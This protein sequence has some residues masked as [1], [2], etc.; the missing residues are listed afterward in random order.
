MRQL[1]GVAFAALLA[2]GCGGGGGP[3]IDSDVRSR[4]QSDKQGELDG[5]TCKSTCDG[6]QCGPDGCGGQCGQCEGKTEQ[7]SAEGLCEPFPCKS[8]K[9]CPGN[10]VCDETLERCVACLADEDCPQGLKCGADQACHEEHT[11][12]AD[13]ECKEFDLVCDKSSGKCVE[14]LKTEHCGEGEYCQEGFCIALI[15]EPAQAKCEG[16]Q[17]LVCTADGSGWALSQTCEEVQYC[18]D[19]KCVDLACKPSSRFCEGDLRKVCAEDGKSVV[20]QED[21]AA[22]NK[23]CFDGACIEGI[24]V[25]NEKFCV[26]GATAATCLADGTN[27][28]TLP[29]EGQQFCQDGACAAWVC[30]PGKAECAGAVARICNSLG[31]GYA[32]QMD[33]Q[34]QGKACIDGQCA[35]CEPQCQGKQCGEDGCGGNCGTCLPD[36]QC[37][38]GSCASTGLDCDLDGS[39]DSCPELTGYK[40]Y[41]NPQ[42]RCEYSN[43]D[44]TGWK[45]WD[46]WIWIPP[47]MFQMGS[48][49]TEVWHKPTEEPLHLVTFKKG[50]F[51]GKYEI[52][53]EQYFACVPSLFCPEYPSSSGG[54]WGLN[55][56]DNGRSDHPQNGLSRAAAES[57]CQWLSPGGRLPSEAEWECSAK[58][59]I[60]RKYPWGDLPAPTCDNFTAVFDDDSMFGEPWGCSDCLPPG[61]SGTMPVGSMQAGAAWSGAMDMAGNVNEWVSDAWHENYS[62]APE[63]GSAW[64]GGPY[65]GSGVIRGGDYMS[66]ASQIRTA[67]RTGPILDPEIHGSTSGARCVRPAEE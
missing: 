19:G 14:C 7:C 63:D 48:P 18:E 62:G 53:V 37:L 17:V 57:F 55:T 54:A 34:A 26:D 10:L 31:S 45:K 23:N 44:A 66:V 2:L 36:E 16:E 32:S 30:E 15:C 42:Q 28:S 65:A 1:S 13:K 60:H 33:C 4:V 50:F 12:Q 38:E 58:G 22:A 5:D 41:C 6:R 9:D 35:S 11:C 3:A 8:S 67:S 20:S 21:C 51:I 24:C 52:V 47:G 43:L 56:P 64:I 27:F 25:P 49:N 61:C 59:P 39:D 46:V 40:R 29:C